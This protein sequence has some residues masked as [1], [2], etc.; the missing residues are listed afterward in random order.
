MPK[1]KH[2]ERK[3]MKRKT[4]VVGIII[5]VFLI[6][7]VSAGLLDIFGKITGSVEVKAPVFYLDGSV[8][9]I[10]PYT[11]NLAYRYLS[12]NIV[13][14]DENVTYLLN[15]NRLI[16]ISKPLGLDYFY[17][18]AFNIKIRVKTNEESNL[19][20]L[21]I[22]KIDENMVESEICEPVNPI[23]ISSW[24]DEFRIRETSCLSNGKIILNPTDR[25]GLEIR[26]I[27][28]TAEYWIKT[29]YESSS[30][31]SSRIEVTAI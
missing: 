13:P 31:G 14:E 6:G 22:I 10:E 26:G 28:G 18:S 7:I 27:G 15:G 4:I 1:G 23:N 25:I 12:T 19:L 21:R 16:Y 11:D 30:T 3:A 20:Q 24:Y 29:A 5:S 8:V 17:D 2:G 9:P